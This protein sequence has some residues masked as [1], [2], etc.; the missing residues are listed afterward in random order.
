MRAAAL[1]LR[2]TPRTKGKWATGRICWIAIAIS[3]PFCKLFLGCHHSGCHR[4]DRGLSLA[5]PKNSLTRPLPLEP[6]FLVLLHQGVGLGQR[7]EAIF[8]VAQV[9]SD[10]R[11]HNVKEWDEQRC[12]SG[13]PGGDPLVD[14][15]QPRLTLALNGQRPAAQDRS[16]GRPEW[17][18]L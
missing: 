12:P 7:L 5:S 17:K 1:P 10:L 8:R 16:H 9:V 18:A 11:Q 6:G 2:T 13:P 14:L 15:S 3:P 4:D